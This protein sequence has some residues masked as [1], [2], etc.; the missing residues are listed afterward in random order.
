MLLVVV[1]YP[2]LLLNDKTFLMANLELGFVAN[3]REKSIFEHFRAHK[4]LWKVNSVSIFM[5]GWSHHFCI[6][7]FFFF[8]VHTPLFFKWC[9]R[10]QKM[11]IKT[12]EICWKKKIKNE[13]SLMDWKVSDISSEKPS[14]LRLLNEHKQKIGRRNRAITNA[15]NTSM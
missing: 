4:L 9:V 15:K 6:Y 7:V 11:R 2:K 14:D 10:E 3:V 8:F 1:N 5:I 13:I 12:T